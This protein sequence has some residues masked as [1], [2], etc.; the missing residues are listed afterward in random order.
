MAAPLK[1][2]AQLWHQHL[3]RHDDMETFI[4][5]QRHQGGDDVAAME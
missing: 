3:Y 2:R 1:M 4:S 5:G